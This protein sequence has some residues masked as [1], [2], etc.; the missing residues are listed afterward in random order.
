[1]LC[2]LVKR[3]KSGIPVRLKN[4]LTTILLHGYSI[5]EVIQIKR[6]SYLKTFTLKIQFSAWITFREL[7]LTI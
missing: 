6:E 4:E 7:Y 3:N 2:K 5:E 1:M